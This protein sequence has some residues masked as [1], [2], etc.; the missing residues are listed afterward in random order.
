MATNCVVCGKEKA[1]YKCPRCRCK[2][3]SV[4]C[5]GTH[6]SSS[7]CGGTAQGTPQPRRDAAE[8]IVAVAGR[9]RP[10]VPAE[11]LLYEVTAD[12]LRR[13]TQLPKVQ[14]VITHLEERR[15]RQVG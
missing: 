15:K 7:Q 9:R 13:V 3:C 8:G 11:E 2:Y 5:F 10:G 1:N 12:A 4:A 14:E 6:K